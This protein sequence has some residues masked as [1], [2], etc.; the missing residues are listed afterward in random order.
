MFLSWAYRELKE[1]QE[2]FSI[3]VTFSKWHVILLIQGIERFG[4]GGMFPRLACV[5]GHVR[6][7]SGIQQLPLQ[8]Q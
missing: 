3:I 5:E 4:S 1:I 7:L 8:L 2:F 6:C